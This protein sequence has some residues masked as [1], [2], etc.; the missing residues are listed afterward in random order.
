MAV[1]L[2]RKAGGTPCFD[3]CGIVVVSRPGEYRLAYPLSAVHDNDGTGLLSKGESVVGTD[4]NNQSRAVA[5]AA[6]GADTCRTV[7]STLWRHKKAAG[8][9][10]T[11]ENYRPK[12]LSAYQHLMDLMSPSDHPLEVIRIKEEEKRQRAEAEA[13][14]GQAP[15][16]RARGPHLPRG[17][18]ASRRGCRGGQWTN[19]RWHPFSPGVQY[20]V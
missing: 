20:E 15:L 4:Y 2:W 17:A 10:F 16:Q 5:S 12:K 6:A 11:F 9:G 18:E 1:Y 3:N 8:P 7:G 19:T 14:G 13:K